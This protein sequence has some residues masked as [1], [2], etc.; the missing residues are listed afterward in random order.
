MRSIN[1]NKES[2]RYFAIAKENGGGNKSQKSPH[3]FLRKQEGVARCRRIRASLCETIG[4]RF[5]VN[6]DWMQNHIANCPRC[7]RRLS[8]AGKVNLA[9]SVVKSQP[10]TLELLM[11]ANTQAIGVLKHSLREAPKAWKLRTMLPE[12]KLLERWSKYGHC[13]ANLAAC[14]AVL[15]LM[16]IGVFSSMDAFQTQGQKVIKQYYTGQVGKDLADEIFAKDTERQ[17][18]AV[19]PMNESS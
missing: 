16:K 19:Q 9:L 5:G 1:T 15:L 2:L 11:R 7:Q 13:T 3:A 17:S 6:A 4:S 12:P 8:L 18:R 14:I 10:H